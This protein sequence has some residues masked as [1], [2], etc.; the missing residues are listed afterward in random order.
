MEAP[1][2]DGGFVT[3]LPVRAR[4]DHWC[5]PLRRVVVA[6][7]SM[8]PALVPGDRLLVVR[9]LRYRPGELV[10]L[11]DPRRPART[12]VKR[13]GAAVDGGR[14]YVVLGDRPEASTDSRTFGPV[15]R[16]AVHGR[17]VY[18]YAPAARAGRLRAVASPG[19]PPSPS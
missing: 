5:R 8:A 7:E 13:V 11:A 16:A 15:P 4:L 14:A 2:G 9:G 17:A 1:C 18:R 19:W 3:N 10:A 6:G 12:L